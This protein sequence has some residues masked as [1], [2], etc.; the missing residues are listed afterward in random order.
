MPFVIRENQKI[1]IIS[2]CYLWVSGFEKMKPI[3]WCVA[4][5]KRK[6]VQAIGA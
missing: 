4:K 5:L 1:Y 2:T 3:M 6:E